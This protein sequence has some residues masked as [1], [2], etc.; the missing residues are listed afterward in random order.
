M[1]S[2]N[3]SMMSKNDERYTPPILVRPIVNYIKEH[4]TIWCPFDTAESEFV[5]ILTEAGHK[6]I[7]SHIWNGEDFFE[8]YPNVAFDCIISNPPFSR[9][10][11]VLER[12]YKIGK[13]F[14]MLMNIECLNYQIIGEF[15]TQHPLQ[16]LIFDK[17]VSFDGN[18]A[19]F[20]TSYFCNG[21]LP[22]DLMFYHLP[23]NNTGTN[24]VGSD[25]REEQT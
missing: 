10:I 18:T 14:A 20:N 21:M 13:P 19:S 16:L 3:K 7:Y 9:K 8:F 23:H 11:E 1:K 15:F 17:K 6:V 25:M 12:L 24:F 4:S 5:K 2:I 22:K